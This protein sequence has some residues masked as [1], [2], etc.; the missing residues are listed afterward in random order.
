MDFSF[1]W[2]SIILGLL[3]TCLFA[4]CIVLV[5]RV[6]TLKNKMD[7]E[8]E[9]IRTQERLNYENKQ[10]QLKMM[11]KESELEIKAEYEDMMNLAKKAKREQDE[12]LAEI[13]VELENA[14]FATQR[15]NAEFEICK[16]ARELASIARDEYIEKLS[17]ISNVNKSEIETE[18]KV[19]LQKKCAE[20]LASYKTELL[21]KSKRDVDLSARR[22]L[23]DAM[24]RISAQ[25]PQSA[26]ATIVKIP[27]EAMKGRLIGKE[28]RNIRS[29]E[30]ETS[31]TLVI[32]ESPETV[33]ISS[34]NPMRRAI[35]KCALETLVNDGRI[36]PS[37]IEQ[38]VAQAKDSI[39]S[40]IIE[41]GDETIASLGI[42]SV[43]D[44]IK[45][46]VGKLSLHLSLNQDTL[47]HS[48][49]VAKLSALIAT[50]LGCD[51]DIARRAG[52]FHDIGKTISTSDASHSKA[53]AE[54]LRRAGE[55]IVVVNAVESHHGEVKAESIYST[56]VQIAD[57]ISATRIG[58]RMEAAEGY[59]RRVRTL[60][61]I[62]QGFEG[63]SS[64]YVLQAGRELRVIVSPDLLDDIQA[65]EVAV[66][67][68][69][70]ID[71][72][73]SN[74]LPI[75]VSVIRQQRFHA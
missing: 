13:T 32:D 35:A 52:L 34:F 20:E 2:N 19:Q 74:S 1:D 47:E 4:E 50:E 75:K 43:S 36:T 14:K 27:D 73:I 48:I 56:I 42:V 21:E 40:H 41:L 26:T 49:E 54:L 38:A 70:K 31:T 68:R 46:A 6:N 65:Q 18:A 16:K 55:S 45:E 61:G 71:A 53:G 63:V 29:F 62:A 25:M 39:T 37:T 17:T 44:E 3:A 22:I 64:A 33:M 8:A 69:E 58:A 12:K 15:A 66:K 9:S 57:S 11:L 59:I 7:A 60:E 24:Q 67:I 5:V 28:G 72:T 23:M 30:Y 10:N 51:P